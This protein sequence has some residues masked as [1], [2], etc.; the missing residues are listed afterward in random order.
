MLFD[1]EGIRVLHRIN[2]R[3]KHAYLQVEHDGTVVLKSNGKNKQALRAFILSKREW[4][5]K[6][7]SR[8]LSHPSITLGQDILYLGESLPLDEVK[9]HTFRTGSLETMRRSYDRFY[10]EQ[11]ERHLQEKTDFFAGRLGVGYAQV[12]FRKMKRRWGSCS[13]TGIITYNTLLMQL[14]EAM[15]D[16]TVVHELAHRVHFNHSADFHALVASIV[17]EE[18]ALR[19][20]MRYLKAVAY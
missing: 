10:R 9:T 18:K 3:M 7:Q 15:I 16:Y 8:L 11:A 13:K 5:A 14:P 12:R 2:P 4:I 19:A 20:R 6:Q 17:P 1:Y